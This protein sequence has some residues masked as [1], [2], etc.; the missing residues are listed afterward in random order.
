MLKPK[1]AQIP[2][3]DFVITF[4]PKETIKSILSNTIDSYHGASSIMI[5]LSYDS[6][7]VLNRSMR[8]IVFSRAHMVRSMPKGS[9][10]IKESDVI[11]KNL[12][13]AKLSTFTYLKELNVKFFLPNLIWAMNHRFNNIA[14]YL[15]SNLYQNPENASNPSKCRGQLLTTL[16]RCKGEDLVKYLIE[17]LEF[18][19]NED[20]LQ[21]FSQAFFYGDLPMA[22]YL[23][24][25]GFCLQDDS[26]Y[27]LIREC[28][29]S[30]GLSML[31][32]LVEMGMN[33]LMM[34][35]QGLIDSCSRPSNNI[36]MAEYFLDEGADIHAQLDEALRRACGSECWDMVMLLIRRRADI[37]SRAGAIFTEMVF[38]KKSKEFLRGVIQLGI[39]DSSIDLALKTC[40]DS[41]STNYNSEMIKFLI[42]MGATQ[43]GID[44]AFVNISNQKNM[45]M[46]RYLIKKGA[47]VSANSN[48]PI[49]NAC[50]NTNI[51]LIEFLRD[52]GADIRA[53]DDLALRQAAQNGNLKIV[54]YLVDAG[55]DPNALDSDAI[56]QIKRFNAHQC[57]VIRFLV[58]K[59]VNVKAKNNA[60]IKNSVKYD[61]FSMFTYLLENGVVLDE[62]R[63]EV[64]RLA[65]KYEC[66]SVLKF[67]KKN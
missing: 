31:K 2:I 18:N 55:A 40:S 32:L 26:S 65:K 57:Q 8:I 42:E 39:R 23:I 44:A 62:V 54:E 52:H 3:Y 58:E 45:G 66:R 17:D 15:V 41:N 48:A 50:S 38:K 27:P 12:P 9:P 43:D 20:G 25:H 13:L 16:I 7:E 30:R 36:K 67:L 35:N 61:K 53:D 64:E 37:N 34:D 6:K 63:D 46:I 11:I 60:L 47:N 59:G 28:I 33:P 21:G 19:V 22:K 1:R 4:I 5:F 14:S 51:P 49:L 29:R 24:D 56:T 10:K